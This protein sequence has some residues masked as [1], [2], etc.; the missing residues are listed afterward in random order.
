MEI[1]TWIVTNNHSGVKAKTEDEA[2]EIARSLREKHGW[3]YLVCRVHGAMHSTT[4]Y[5]E[6]DKE[7][8]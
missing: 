8:S 2:I 3:T 7:E 4:I 1:P 5:T 6:A